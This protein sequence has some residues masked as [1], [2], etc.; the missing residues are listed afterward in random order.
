VKV[1]YRYLFCIPVTVST[2]SGV[3]QGNDRVF[4]NYFYYGEIINMGCKLQKKT[5]AKLIAGV[6]LWSKYDLTAG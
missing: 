1:V 4:E 6:L 3:N 2:E 5:P